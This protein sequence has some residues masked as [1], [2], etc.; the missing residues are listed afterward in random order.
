MGGR[1][2]EPR[3]GLWGVVTDCLQKESERVTLNSL[4]GQQSGWSCPHW[5]RE[6]SWR[7]RFGD[8]VVSLFIYLSAGSVL[9]SIVGADDTAGN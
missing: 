5:E 7:S 4:L 1:S 6:P 2:W 9:G 3:G 8:K